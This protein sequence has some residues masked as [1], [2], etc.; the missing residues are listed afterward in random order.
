MTLLEGRNLYLREN[1]FSMSTYEERWARIPLL[2]GLVVA[3]PSPVSRGHA[4]RMHDFHHVLTGYGTD[5]AGEAEISAWEL[6][7]GLRGLPAYVKVLVLSVLF[8]GLVLYPRRT[9]RA[10]RV[11]PG[12]G[13][14]FGRH[15]QYDTLLARK[16]GE[17]RAELGLPCEG[18]ASARKLH[19]EAPRGRED[20]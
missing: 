7:R 12:K 6:S 3:I 5:I 4:L 17:L 13:S 16:V 15:A 14:L 8:M 11:A 2:W 1:G 20:A 9:W 19:A 18:I 10:L